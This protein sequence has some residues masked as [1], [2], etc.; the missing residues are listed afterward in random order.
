MPVQTVPTIQVQ[1][2]QPVP[3]LFT[4]EALAF[5]QNLTLRFGDRLEALLA[6]RAEAQAGFDAG[7]RPGFLPE[8]APIRQ[9]DWSV[10]PLPAAL[11]DRR[12]EIT[13]P[14]EAKML[15][16]ALNSGARVYM[17]D[18]EDSLAPTLENLVTGQQNLYLAIRGSLR[19]RT[20]AG[21]TGC[22]TRWPP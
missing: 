2:P 10:A 15:I 16:N 3:D 8:T 1:H 17:A 6:A 18:F 14:P 9:G 12:V 22:R 4:T 19:H 21:S 13:G 11:L 5:V 20:P 7:R